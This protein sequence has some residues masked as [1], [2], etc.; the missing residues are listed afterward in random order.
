MRFCASVLL[1]PLDVVRKRLSNS[2]VGTLQN[3]AAYWLAVVFIILY[4]LRQNM[5]F[6]EWYFLKE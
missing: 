4:W 2:V 3:A 5:L 1:N 6:A